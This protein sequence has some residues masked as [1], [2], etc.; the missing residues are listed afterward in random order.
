MNVD[1]KRSAFD[2]TVQRGEA[3]RPEN[4]MSGPHAHH[5]LGGFQNW[6]HRQ[7]LRR[8]FENEDQ[9]RIRADLAAFFGSDSEDYL[10]FYEKRRRRGGSWVWSWSWAFI[11]CP[12]AWHFFRKMYVGGVCMILVL[13]MVMLAA[14]D[15]LL[16]TFSF[17]FFAV[18][19]KPSY[20]NMALRRIRK[21]DELG[22]TGVER[23][24]Y[25]RT[26]GGTSIL[27][28]TLSTLV[29]VVAVNGVYSGSLAF[30]TLQ[31]LF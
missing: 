12:H 5:V 10:S 20:L 14:W 25:L 2:P 4:Q 28:G 17:I 26:A 3:T 13:V 29:V 6:K 22:L 21:A 8:F 24:R 31:K 23:S 27:A 9:D 15:P 18:V 19:A 30:A 1:D 11:S 7:R 16:A